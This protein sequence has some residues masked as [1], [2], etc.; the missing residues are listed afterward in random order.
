[1]LTSAYNMQPKTQFFIAKFSNLSTIFNSAVKLF[2]ELNL[3]FNTY[4][5]REVNLSGSTRSNENLC[6]KMAAIEKSGTSSGYCSTDLGHSFI[7]RRYA[8]AS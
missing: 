2:R 4:I 6:K 8:Y 1:M 7:F 5:V 3:L